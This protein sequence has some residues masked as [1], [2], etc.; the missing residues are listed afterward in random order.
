MSNISGSYGALCL[1]NKRY[2][3]FC[4]NH[5]RDSYVWLVGGKLK[6]P[7]ILSSTASSDHFHFW[8]YSLLCSPCLSREFLSSKLSL[9][10][11]VFLLP[12][13]SPPAYSLAA[14]HLSDWLAALAPA[15]L[16]SSKNKHLEKNI[17]FSNDCAYFFPVLAQILDFLPLS[18]LGDSA[19]VSFQFKVSV[20][21]SWRVGSA[22]I[23][24]S[25]NRLLAFSVK[26][27]KKGE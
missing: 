24:H 5:N 11:S 22:N 27:L 20:T 1:F 2:S 8:I 25:T 21:K 4:G 6:C 10:P 17:T 3:E 12:Q 14:A 13:G 23:N 9:A 26:I 15:C 18:L 7:I 16:R 19:D